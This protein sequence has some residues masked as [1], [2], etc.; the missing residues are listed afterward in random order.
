[1]TIPME[2]LERKNELCNEFMIEWCNYFHNNFKWDELGWQ[3]AYAT[4]I[5]SAGN[6]FALY[7]YHDV[8]TALVTLDADMDR[9]K[10]RLAQSMKS[11]L[12]ALAERDE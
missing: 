4:I 12:E 6:L 1:M 3:D 10:E 2:I 11:H 9:M 5:S 7:G 8:E